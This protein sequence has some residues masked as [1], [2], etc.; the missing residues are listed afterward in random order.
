MDLLQSYFFMF[1]DLLF[2][3]H[4]IFYGNYLPDN[5]GETYEIA[6]FVTNMLQTLSFSILSSLGILFKKNSFYVK[7]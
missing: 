2:T 7:I 1:K 3:F 5:V 6:K 4:F